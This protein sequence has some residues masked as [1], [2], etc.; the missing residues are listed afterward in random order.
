MMGII[1][2]DI[3]INIHITN[4]ITDINKIDLYHIIGNAM[5]TGNYIQVYL[6]GLK[7]GIWIK[8]LD[9]LMNSILIKYKI[10]VVELDDYNQVDELIK[11]NNT[12]SNSTESYEYSIITTNIITPL[13]IS[14][15]KLSEL[16]IK[17]NNNDATYIK[18]NRKD[19]SRYRGSKASCMVYTEL[20]SILK[21][22]VIKYIPN[23]SMTIL[24]VDQLEKEIPNTTSSKVVSMNKPILSM[25][26]RILNTE[27]IS[28]SIFTS[29]TTVEYLIKQHTKDKP[30]TSIFIILDT[31]DRSNSVNHNNN[32]H[33]IQIDRYITNNLL[34]S[35]YSIILK[36]LYKY[37]V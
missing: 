36:N 1:N 10:I 31:I 26:D 16:I 14:N 11:Y 6:Y 19:Q 12:K 25:F 2:K 33:Y 37:I 30:N 18:L 34:D 22:L 13:F 9:E 21:T 15:S 4:Y 35:V 3:K 8:H 17:Y 32:S 29:G 5:I 24:Y 27:V 28:C 20:I 7:D 23:L